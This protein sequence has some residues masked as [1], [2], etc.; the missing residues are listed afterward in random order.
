[1]KVKTYA[2]AVSLLARRKAA[3]D[4]TREGRLF[5]FFEECDKIAD[6]YKVNY[7]QVQDDLRI[8]FKKEE[9][10]MND[11]NQRLADAYRPF[12]RRCH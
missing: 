1:M 6:E 10:I 5:K 3:A 12:I 4:Q 7:K 2:E 8:E 11:Y 9:K